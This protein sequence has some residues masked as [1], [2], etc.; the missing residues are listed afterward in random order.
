MIMLMRV[1]DAKV[2]QVIETCDHYNGL[3]TG[4][5][6]KIGYETECGRILAYS[7][8]TRTHITLHPLV[9]CRILDPTLLG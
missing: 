9:R 6:Y 5:I 8:Y 3:P 7:Y 4:N 1:R 2:G